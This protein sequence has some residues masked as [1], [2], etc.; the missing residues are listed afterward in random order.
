MQSLKQSW[1][2]FKSSILRYRVIFGAAEGVVLNYLSEVKQLNLKGYKNW[3]KI[4]ICLKVSLLTFLIFSRDILLFF[5]SAK[6]EKAHPCSQAQCCGS[7]SLFF[8]TYHADADSYADRILIYLF[9]ADPD[10]DPSFKKGSNHWKSAK[11]GSYSIHFGL[12][13]ENWFGSGSGSSL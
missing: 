13:Y 2:G 4:V 12:T 11:I 7:S 1:V 3:R 10:P 5:M 6:I 9:D 8:L